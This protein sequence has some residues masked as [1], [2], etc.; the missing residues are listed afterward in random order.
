M[1]QQSDGSLGKSEGNYRVQNRQWQAG[2]RLNLSLGALNM[3]PMMVMVSGRCLLGS[4]YPSHLCWS[5]SHTLSAPSPSFYNRLC[6]AGWSPADNSP[7]P[8]VSLV[9][10]AHSRC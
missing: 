5:L 7:L 8:V 1:R 6:D 3:L 2:P 4:S 9:G 10:S